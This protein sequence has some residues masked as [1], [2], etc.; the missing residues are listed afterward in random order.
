[1]GDRKPRSFSGS[2]FYRS[3]VNYF[4]K[5][6]PNSRILY[7]FFINISRRIVR[8]PTN[9]V[10]LPVAFMPT[11]QEW[12]VDILAQTKSIFDN[13]QELHQKSKKLVASDFE[14]VDLDRRS[15]T[16]TLAIIQTAF[17]SGWGRFR[18]EASDLLTGQLFLH[19]ISA[20]KYRSR[21]LF[22]KP[23]E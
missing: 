7:K 12:Q 10:N 23:L 16:R 2:R 19:Y 4:T 1:M 5:D 17:S 6:G 8:M 20:L 3:G 21:I 11:S 9:Q 18:A 13:I 14:L 22:K 15:T